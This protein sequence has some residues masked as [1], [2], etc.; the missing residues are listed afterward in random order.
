M[1]SFDDWYAKYPASREQHEKVT[2]ILRAAY[3]AGRDADIED[4]DIRIAE[5]EAENERLEA[6]NRS[7]LSHGINVGMERAAEI[8]A[9]TGRHGDHSDSPAS[10]YDAATA[11]RKE[12]DNG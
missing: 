7:I 12:I 1:S 5:L 9:R 4:R 2:E 11:I 6:A 8:A 10:A 3:N